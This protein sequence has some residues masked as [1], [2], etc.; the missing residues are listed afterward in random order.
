MKVSKKDKEALMRM[1]GLDE[2]IEY[3]FEHNIRYWDFDEELTKKKDYL[4]DHDKKSDKI[5]IPDEGI[6]FSAFAHE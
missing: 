2:F 5:I 4:Y 3:T 6:S 1:T